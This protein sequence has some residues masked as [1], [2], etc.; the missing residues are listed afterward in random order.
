MTIRA[1]GPED[2]SEL[3]DL[4][5]AQVTDFLPTWL[6]PG[7]STSPDIFTK[8]EFRCEAPVSTKVFLLPYPVMS[9]HH[10]F[11]DFKERFETL[12]P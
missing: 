6:R 10:S 1:W 3:E 7:I 12:G 4:F 2:R 11:E 9:A 5:Q 8:L